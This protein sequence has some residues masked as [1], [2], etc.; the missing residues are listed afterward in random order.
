MQIRKLPNYNDSF[1]YDDIPSRAQIEKHRKRL[2][3]SNTILIVSG[4]IQLLVLIRAVI[5][6]MIHYKVI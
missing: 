4:T 3:I 2:R 5:A 6:I 1:G